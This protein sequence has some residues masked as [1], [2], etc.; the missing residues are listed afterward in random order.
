MNEEI[1]ASENCIN[2]LKLADKYHMEELAGKC[3]VLMLSNFEDLSESEE[4]MLLSFAEI[5]EHSQSQDLQLPIWTI[6]Q[7]QSVNL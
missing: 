7:Q 2:L 4:F 3:K 1:L 6:A 5:K